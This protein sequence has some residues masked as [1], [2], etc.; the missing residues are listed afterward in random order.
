ME[1]LTRD[2]RYSIRMLFKSPGFTVVAVLSLALAIGANTT[3]FTIV[4][5]V[6][7]Q[8]LPV[9]DIS[10]LAQV[11]TIDESNDI[12][13][14][15]FSPTSYVN[16]VDYRE[17]ND[18]FEGL[19]AVVGAGFTMTGRGDPQN[20]PGQL[21]SGDYFDVLGVNPALGR[22]FLPEEDE[23][24][25]TH[26]VAVIS[27]SLWSR[28]FGSD[29][30]LIGETLT[31][32]GFAFTVVG[33]T[34]PGFK[35]INTLSQPDQIWV[36]MSMH[37]QVIIGTLAEFFEAR[38]AL[39]TQIFGRLEA[40][41]SMGEADAAMKTIAVRLAEQYPRDNENR[42]VALVPMAEAATGIN[43]RDQFRMA[44]GLLMGVVGLVLLI[45]CVNLANL[46]LAR[47][48]SRAREVG[49]RTAMGAARS[50]LFRQLL[51]E[52][53][54][55]SALGGASALLVAFWARD[56]LWSF[57]PPFLNEDAVEL[58]LDPNV[59]LF[60]LAVSML[61]GLLFGLI[62]AWKLSDPD[63][64]EVLK[65][66]GG[67]QGAGGIGS[68]RIRSVLV[69]SQVALAL[70]ALVSA[71]LFIRS[72]QQAQG[73]DAGFETDRLFVMGMN[74]G[75]DQMGPER[76]LPFLNEALETARSVPGVVNAAVASNFPLSGGFM[77]SVF[78]EGQDQVPGQQDILTLTNAVSPGYFETLG[79]PLLRGRDFDDFDRE[80]APLVAII[81]E[82]T[83]RKFWPDG[84]ALEEK[85]IFF[86]HGDYREVVGIV[87]DS[88]I[89]RVGED[90]TAV[91]YL[92]MEQEYSSFASIQ[93]RTEADPEVVLATVRDEVQAL[94]RNLPITNVSTIDQ[95]F[96]QGLF[97]PRMGA[98]LLGLFGLLALT[99]AAIGIYGV[100]AYSVSQRTHE[101]GIRM[102]LG[103]A[104]RDVVRMLVRQGMTL[105]VI[106]LGAGLVA[107]F[108]VT[109]LATSLLFG[110]SATDP[111]TF[112]A[113][114]VILGVV[115]MTACYIPARGAT[116]ID[117]LDALRID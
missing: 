60:T 10:S 21:V 18:V 15:N 22:T 111:I 42:T 35:G 37:E 46:L 75:S 63:L 98:A 72:M 14:F 20:F 45:A 25:G 43:Q 27:H 16:F 51:T 13:N 108:F 52:S 12:A 102:A 54:V 50:R 29:P 11:Y 73:L 86:D 66:G 2:L 89:I 8:P 79:I 92:P 87:R 104:G 28:Q 96:A 78:M 1:S 26:P 101:I 40:E 31:L 106:G 58:A 93:V 33:V 85:F 17:Q 100:M 39:F 7:L 117:P 30:T 112:A 34:P 114:V 49:I 44:G 105:M 6:L 76:G 64:N 57:R 47:A 109:R 38:R 95:I 48:T 107:A 3:I 5:A 91:I 88:L 116:N 69:V 110:V 65:Q 82:A 77:R 24:L 56:I 32:N 83:A 55:L 103:A 94:N 19:V 99:L 70:V 4:N 23:T 90:P 59:L 67:R 62:P 61:T 113:V 71:G 115:G 81:N 84:E 36:P 9:E 41:V 53:V 80:G 97:A 74:L 68:G